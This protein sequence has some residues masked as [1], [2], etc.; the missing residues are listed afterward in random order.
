MTA[1]SS[2]IVRKYGIDPEVGMPTFFE[3]DLPQGMQI[4]TFKVMRPD[5]VIELFFEPYNPDIA[6]N[7][8]RWG[9]DLMH[10]VLSV[11]LTT[12]G[13]ITVFKS[14]ASHAWDSVQAFT[15]YAK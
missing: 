6:V 15:N 1:E 11:H 10:G 3:G 7:G 13:R 8:S 14:Y 9:Y 2:P 4:Q 12:N 5:N